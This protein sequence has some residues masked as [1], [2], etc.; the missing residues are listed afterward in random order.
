M[1]G[2]ISSNTLDSEVFQSLLRCSV[3][4]LVYT[5]NVQASNLPHSII[6]HFWLVQNL[7][8]SHTWGLGVI[9]SFLGMHKS[10]ACTP[11]CARVQS[12]TFSGTYQR[13]LKLPVSTHSPTFPFKFFGQP[14]VCLKCYH[15][16]RQLECQAVAAHNFHRPGEVLLNEPW[17]SFNKYISASRSLPQTHKTDTVVALM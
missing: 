1:T 6:L 8:V 12:S 17:I 13:S 14:L 10:W 16:L 9:S 7:K 3:C 15:S 11:F 5:F 4:V 2:Q